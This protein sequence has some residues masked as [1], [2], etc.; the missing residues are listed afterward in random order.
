MYNLYINIQQIILLL[1]VVCTSCFSIERGDGLCNTCFVEF[2]KTDIYIPS[3]TV[4]YSW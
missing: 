3:I 4:G 1:T 2:D